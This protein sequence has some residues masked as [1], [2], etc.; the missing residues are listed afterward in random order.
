MRAVGGTQGKQFKLNRP[1]F[2]EK[3]GLQ[4]QKKNPGSDQRSDHVIV[5][6]HEV[7]CAVGREG[8]SG[9]GPD[10]ENKRREKRQHA[11]R[12]RAFTF[13]TEVK[14]KHKTQ[15]TVS[16]GVSERKKFGR[17]KEEKGNGLRLDRGHR[18][19]GRP[20]KSAPE[21]NLPGMSDT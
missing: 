7:R 9:F 19:C 18:Q 12:K 3:R 5:N 6:V 16:G 13:E 2:S 17:P 11:R 10:P 4:H 21:E 14:A 1:G 8:L 20:Q 15:G